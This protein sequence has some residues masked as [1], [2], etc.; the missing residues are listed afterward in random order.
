MKLNQ[1]LVSKNNGFSEKWTPAK[2][3]GKRPFHG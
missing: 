2:T 1:R 3:G